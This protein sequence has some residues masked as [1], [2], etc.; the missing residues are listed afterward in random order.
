MTM[1]SHRHI[2]ILNSIIK[3]VRVGMMEEEEE[4]EVTIMTWPV[5]PGIVIA[6]KHQRSSL[7]AIKEQARKVCNWMAHSF[8]QVADRLTVGGSKNDEDQA[9]M[10]AIS[11]SSIEI[12]VIARADDSSG[13]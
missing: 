2:A 7:A 10:I 6:I 8:A 1:T 11:I 5:W 9:I 4:E 3:L 12:L 13:S